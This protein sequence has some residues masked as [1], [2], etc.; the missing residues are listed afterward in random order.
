[1][2]RHQTNYGG[3]RAGPHIGKNVD[4]GFLKH[5]RVQEAR[6]VQQQQRTQQ[7]YGATRCVHM[8]AWLQSVCDSSRVAL[9][10]L[11][12]FPPSKRFWDLIRKNPSLSPFRPLFCVPRS[13][14]ILSWIYT[15]HL[16]GKTGRAGSCPSTAPACGT[17]AGI[18]HKTEE[19]DVPWIVQPPLPVPGLSHRDRAF[20]AHAGNGMWQRQGLDCWCRCKC[21]SQRNT[22]PFFC[23]MA[24]VVAVL[25]P[26]NLFSRTHIFPIP[27]LHII[28]IFFLLLLL[29]VP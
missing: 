6:N 23:G 27:T 7:R 10:F 5:Q 19:S 29:R 9:P 15:C 22:C 12:V 28:I 24:A 18:W 20:F 8:S 21:H 11:Q 13:S 26:N 16:Q 2:G 1:M 17:A 14:L 4:K 25:D 3:G